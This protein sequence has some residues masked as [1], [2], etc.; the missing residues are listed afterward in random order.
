MLASTMLV[1]AAKHP[2]TYET[3]VK[4]TAYVGVNLEISEVQI[5]EVIVGLKFVEA[6]AFGY[7]RSS[8]Y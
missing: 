2:E 3:M 4:E 8:E 6:E 7:S 5:V 1:Q